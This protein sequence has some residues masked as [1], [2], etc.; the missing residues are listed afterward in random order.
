MR[1]KAMEMGR[2]GNAFLKMARSSRVRHRPWREEQRGW[3]IRGGQRRW[4][5]SH[6]TG[7]KFS[8]F[9]PSLQPIL[10]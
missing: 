5:M 1:P 6:M 3:G 7:S 8:H 9:I 10:S 4:T 2:A